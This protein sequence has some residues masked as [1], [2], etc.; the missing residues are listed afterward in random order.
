[1]QKLQPWLCLGLLPRLHLG[2]GPQTTLR[3]NCDPLQSVT[4]KTETC[5]RCQRV[6]IL[7]GFPRAGANP[8]HLTLRLNMVADLQFHKTSIDHVP[9]SRN[10]DGRLRDIGRQDDLPAPGGRGLENGK[11][12]VEWEGSVQRANLGN[13]FERGL[14]ECWFRFSEESAFRL[15]FLQAR[16][17]AYLQISQ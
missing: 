12:L 16:P 10:R 9:N 4:T 13:Y 5:P 17:N 2:P 11:L 14:S 8:H 6:N 7:I 1:M 3:L 15:P